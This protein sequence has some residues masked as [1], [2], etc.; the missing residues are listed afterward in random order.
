M[1]FVKISLKKFNSRKLE[2]SLVRNISNETNP[3]ST[4][5]CERMEKLQNNPPSSTPGER[6]H[7][8]FP[9]YSVG[10]ERSLK[11]L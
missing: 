11:M 7:F 10:L 5:D 3:C 9:Q 2:K 4:A 1:K 8:P 6:K